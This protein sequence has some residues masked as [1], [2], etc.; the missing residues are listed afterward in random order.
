MEKFDNTFTQMMFDIKKQC[1]NSY[2]CNTL[3]SITGAIFMGLGIAIIRQCQYN[4]GQTNIVDTLTE[5]YVD[6]MKHQ[7]EM[8]NHD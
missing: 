8:E 7:N 2:I 4:L 1:R 6:A 3:G 5:G